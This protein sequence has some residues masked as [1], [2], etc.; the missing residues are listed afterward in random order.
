MEYYLAIKRDNIRIHAI[1]WMK[2]E[3]ITLSKRSQSHSLYIVLCHM[4]EMSRIGKSIETENRFLVGKEEGRMG[5][6]C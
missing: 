3:I 4:Q 5:K 6:E 1:T 2:L